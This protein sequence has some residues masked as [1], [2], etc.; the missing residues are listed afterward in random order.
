MMQQSYPTAELKTE[1]RMMMDENVIEQFFDDW[2]QQDEKQ[3][4]TGLGTRDEGRECGI[5]I[6]YV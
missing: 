3:G 2:A 1:V 5:A 4:E 6:L